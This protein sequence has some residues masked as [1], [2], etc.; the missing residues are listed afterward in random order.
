MAKMGLKEYKSIIAPSDY[1]KGQC[2]VFGCSSHENTLMYHGFPDLATDLRRRKIWIAACTRKDG[3]NPNKSYVCSK[4]FTEDC[5]VQEVTKTPNGTVKVETVLKKDA[6]PNQNLNTQV[7]TEIQSNVVKE[8]VSIASKY[9]NNETSVSDSDSPK[10]SSEQSSLSKTQ[11]QRPF[12]S[13]CEVRNCRDY[14]GQYHFHI[15]V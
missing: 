1:M 13:K 6:I 12:K 14:K 15:S 2:A 8:C 9:M 4:H 10:A 7:L 5:Y 3:F 11:Q